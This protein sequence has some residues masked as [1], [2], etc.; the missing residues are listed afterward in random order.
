MK[1]R[2]LTALCFLLATWGIAKAQTG[3]ITLTI[4]AATNAD[5]GKLVTIKIANSQAVLKTGT[6]AYYP[7]FTTAVTPTVSTDKKTATYTIPYTDA[8][9]TF[10]IADAANQL[11]DVQLTVDGKVTSFKATNK[12]A[13]T[14]FDEVTSLKFTNNGVLK[15]IDMTAF[16][17]KLS[18]L[19]VSGNEL[20]ALT[21]ITHCK[22]L[23]ELLAADNKL[24]EYHGLTAEHEALKKVDLS[25]NAI[26]YAN[27]PAEVQKTIKENKG[28]FTMGTQTY[29]LSSAA[30]SITNWYANNGGNS[31]SQAIKEFFGTEADAKDFDFSWKKINEN[32]DKDVPVTLYSSTSTA[33]PTGD[34]EAI[35][36]DNV[37]PDKFTFRNNS[38]YF[39]GT[40]SV[41][42]KGKS[43]TDY[44]GITYKIPQI[45][46]GAAQFTFAEDAIKDAKVYLDNNTKTEVNPSTIV[47]QGQSLTV[48][49]VKKVGMQLKEFEFTGLALREITKVENWGVFEVTGAVQKLPNSNAV[50]AVP[51][52]LKALYA[53]AEY[54]L[55]VR[56]AKGGE[57]QIS[58]KDENG[59][60]VTVP[61]AH[62][63]LMVSIWTLR[64]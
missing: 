29:Q 53:P 32:A 19:H 5:K 31:L 54:K 55:T 61:T 63:F 27:I 51:L 50:Q 36:Q 21:G 15:E 35:I 28:T 44:S 24:S 45:V 10:N 13:Q 23:T 22:K 4:P 11:K 47:K 34:R 37:Y 9:Q 58:Y 41:E 40:Y 20:T 18:V 59:N 56:S 48:Y 8:V 64:C 49:A 60:P 25:G 7:E 16:A 3:G 33:I 52:T 46:V 26:A 62:P 42:I 57:L 6:G 2:L 17:V 12:S 14:F 30:S 43:N 1:Q 39:Y 38:K